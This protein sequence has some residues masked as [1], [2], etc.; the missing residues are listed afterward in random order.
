MAMTLLA[1]RHLPS[2]SRRAGAGE[3]VVLIHPFMLSHHSWRPVIEHLAAGHDVLAVSMPGHYGGPPLS[4]RATF[5]AMVDHVERE[6]DAVGW[7]TAHVVGN[8]LGGWAALELARRGR[9]RTVTAIAPAGGYDGLVPRDVAM[10]VSFMAFAT[11]RYVLRATTLLPRMPF[12]QLGLKAVAHDPS[13]ID[14]QDARHVARSALGATHPVQVLL[15]CMRSIPA[16]GLETIE[17]PVHL[18]FAGKDLVIPP[19]LYSSYFI[20]RIPHAEVTTL[21]NV[22]HCPQVEEPVMTADLI[23]NFIGRH[24]LA[25][26]A[27]AR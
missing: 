21:E 16:R 13:R 1:R 26:L 25:G 2:G 22:G 4:W 17:V 27:E 5:A 14:P 20:D 15:A 7:R 3:P 18:V 8:S 23:R 10:G 12:Q 6:M 9:A 24:S 19:Q 11:T